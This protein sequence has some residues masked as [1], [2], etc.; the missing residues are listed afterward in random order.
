MA[1]TVE[2][3]K[4]NA[5]DKRR[6]EED[7]QRRRDAEDA[8]RRDRDQAAARHAQSVQ[9]KVETVDKATAGIRATAAAMSKRSE[10]SGSQSLD[11]GEAAR[12]TSE[13]AAIVSDATRQLSQAVDE[14]SHQV[15][16]AH[17]ISQKAV[18]G[19]TQTGRQMEDLARSV[20]SIG[21][22]VALISDIAAQTNLLALNATIEA[23][24]AGEAGKGFAVVAGEVK[25]LA[26]QTAKATEDITRQVA[27]IQ[28]SAKVMGASI[29][30]VAE[31]IRDL[32]GV[33]SAI[34]GAV[35]QQDASTRE[36]SNNVKEVATQAEVVA[37]TV[38][39][40]ATSSAKTCAGT[41]RVIWS[42]KALAETVAGLS[43]ETD[44]FLSQ[45]RH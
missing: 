32:D 16:Y 7:A 17:D 23:A 40:V 12:I 27:E 31:I 5:L 2:V 19:V 42:A 24:R 18:S 26:N 29:D 8:E 44:T 43:T 6:M 39:G 35:Q 4:Q 13:R 15:T 30:G 34:A 36:I 41:I 11:M 9:A 25:N 37:R 1:R 10:H 45:F 21:Q 3:F 28:Q 14:I 38:N 22:V 33:S 20:D